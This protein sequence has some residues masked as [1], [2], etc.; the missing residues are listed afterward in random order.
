[1]YATRDVESDI[2]QVLL[3]RDP[4]FEIE[5]IGK[6]ERLERKCAS[7]E[8]LRRYLSGSARE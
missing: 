4:P 3:L 6:E 7:P 5:I 2:D 1:L 8:K